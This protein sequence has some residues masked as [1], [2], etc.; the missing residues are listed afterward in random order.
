MTYSNSLKAGLG[1]EASDTKGKGQG[2]GK[3]KNEP[4]FNAVRIIKRG[5]G[6][7]DRS[8][9]KVYIQGKRAGGKKVWSEKEQKES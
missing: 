7:V 1:G 3:K 9:T 2:G 8:I 5:G 6:Y 4:L